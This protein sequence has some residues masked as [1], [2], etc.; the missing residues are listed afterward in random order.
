MA[1]LLRFGR[2]KD[3]G[4]TVRRPTAIRKPFCNVTVGPAGTGTAAIT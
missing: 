1:A 3:D 4:P 2:V